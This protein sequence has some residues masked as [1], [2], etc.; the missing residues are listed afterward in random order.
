M[1]MWL[2]LGSILLQQQ[3]RAPVFM[4]AGSRCPASV[5]HMQSLI[6]AWQVTCIATMLCYLRFLAFQRLFQWLCCVCLLC[7]PTEPGQDH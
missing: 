6:V 3:L 2:S 4:P 5:A 1:H 7:V